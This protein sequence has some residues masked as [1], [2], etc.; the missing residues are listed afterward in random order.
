MQHHPV[1]FV[2]FS[3]GKVKRKKL[4]KETKNQVNEKQRITVVFPLVLWLFKLNQGMQKKTPTYPRKKI[5]AKERTNR[6][7]AT[8]VDATKK[9]N[10][11]VIIKQNTVDMCT[12]KGGRH[13][14]ELSP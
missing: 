5:K 10:K 14:K 2:Q 6:R 9:N 4:T 13:Y 7:K 1:V 12:Y 8:T 3:H 11:A